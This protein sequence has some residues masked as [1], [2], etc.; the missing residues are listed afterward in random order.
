MDLPG[1]LDVGNRAIDRGAVDGR[2]MPD[3]DRVVVL[4]CLELFENDHPVIE[5]IR[6]GDLRR[7]PVAVYRAEAIESR[8]ASCVELVGDPA[9]SEHTGVGETLSQNLKTGPVIRMRM[10]ENDPIDGLAQRLHV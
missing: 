3:G 4:K 7:D 8:L 2:V 9:Q 10:R 1:A 5:M 6:D